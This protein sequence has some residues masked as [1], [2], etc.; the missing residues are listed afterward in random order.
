M[1]C[2]SLHQGQSTPTCVTYLLTGFPWRNNIIFNILH[3]VRILIKNAKISGWINGPI[4]ESK[5]KRYRHRLLK[6]DINKRKEVLCDLKS[7]VQIAHE[8]SRRHLRDIMGYSLD[9]LSKPQNDPAAGYPELLHIDTLKGYFGEIFAGIIAENFSPFGEDKWEVP[10][11]LFRFHNQAFEQLERLRQTGGRAKQIPGRTG[12]DCLAFLRDSNGN[13]IKSLV[14]EAKCTADHAANMIS[15]A[16]EKISEK[17]L[18][19]VALY[20]LIEVLREN[21][22]PESKQW[23]SSLRKLFMDDKK[24]KYERL[25]L[26]SYICGRSP[27]QKNRYSWI[28][29]EEPHSKYQRKR[30]LEAVEIH[31]KNVKRIIMYVYNKKDD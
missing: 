8:D 18:T 31:L 9:P 28:P 19:P 26:V 7:I 23:V 20:Q 3:R 14:C 2:L 6:E 4:K 1:P 30:R 25:D 21:N 10:V 12:D 16:H 24:D 15:D 29:E 17:N 5:G 27:K 22:T 13:I 11:F